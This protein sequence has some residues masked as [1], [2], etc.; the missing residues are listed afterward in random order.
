[1]SDV[2]CPSEGRGVLVHEWLAR[3]GGSENVF[4]VLAETF[5]TA[6]LLCLWSDVPGRYPGR[7]LQETWLARTRLRSQKAAAL[8][9]APWTWRRR[10][11]N[12]DWALVSSH[13]FAHHVSF[14]EPSDDFRKYVYVHSPARYVW[15]P[16]LDRRGSSP[17][18]RTASAVLKRIDR[19]RA[20]EIH[21]AAA[22]SEF[23]RARIERTWGIDSTV[24]YPPVEV[25]RIQDVPDWADRLSS[26]DE[27]ALAAVPAEF[28]LGAS[29]LIPYKDLDSVVRAGAATGL[30]V[31]IAGDGPERERLG[32]LA[33]D[34]SVRVTFLGRVSDELLY[35]LYQ[36]CLAYLFPAVEDF[37]I[38]PV[39][40]MAAGA[41]VITGLVG[42]AVES[43]QSGVA[44]AHVDF[45]D[46]PEVA[47]AVA[48]VV[49][50]RGAGPR[51]VAREFS[52]ERFVAQIR[53]FVGGAHGAA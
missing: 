45:A 47:R 26:V 21:A 14:A 40:A 10:P 53:S 43:V 37:G 46:G 9:V 36:R 5:P 24:I 11:G 4:D 15:E 41:P 49:A 1:M 19:R 44:G 6:D 28:L 30:P 2:S 18:A 50:L 32:A 16:E 13:Q 17:A 52:R 33:C 48:S 29:R 20:R 12:Y 27:R 7:V 38:M 31:V 34:L 23:V 3:T 8:L 51:R 35:A 39:E 22:N 25:A 42:G